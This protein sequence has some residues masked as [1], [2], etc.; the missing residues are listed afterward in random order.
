MVDQSPCLVAAEL[1]ISQA[2]IW[3]PTSQGWPLGCGHGH[4]M[5]HGQRG[6]PPGSARG[7]GEVQPW[8]DECHR[9]AYNQLGCFMGTDW[10]WNGRTFPVLAGNS[11]VQRDLKVGHYRLAPD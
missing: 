2:T 5:H 11:F 9:S 4:P 7:G 6:S 3:D 1:G 8:A 10:A